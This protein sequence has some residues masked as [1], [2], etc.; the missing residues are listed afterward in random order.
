MA[1]EEGRRDIGIA[2]YRTAGKLATQLLPVNIPAKGRSKKAGIECRDKRQSGAADGIRL[3][4]TKGEL[5]HRRGN[6]R[7]KSGGFNPPEKEER[8]MRIVAANMRPKGK[9]ETAAH[10]YAA[11]RRYIRGD[12]IV[13]GGI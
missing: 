4:W 8:A 1:R 12:A 10:K 7:K 2:V 13:G 9:S 3:K 5:S 11:H 6:E